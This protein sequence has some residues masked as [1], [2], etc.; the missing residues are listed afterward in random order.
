MFFNILATFAAFAADLIRLRT[1]K[2][3]AIAWAKGKLGGKKP[4]LSDKQQRELG[5]MLAIGDYSISDRVELFTLSRPTVY[6]ALARTL[7]STAEAEQ[8]ARGRLARS[9]QRR[10]ALKF[11]RH[12]SLKVTAVAQ[13]VRSILPCARPDA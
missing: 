9:D 3:T 7:N 5:R 10:I 13:G 1:R 11:D 8:T 4:K 12:L 6:R 2:G